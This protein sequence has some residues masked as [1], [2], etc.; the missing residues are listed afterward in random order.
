[1]ATVDGAGSTWNIGGSLIV[2]YLGG[3]GTLTIQNGGVVSNSL[4]AVGFA[5]GSTG[6]VT[7]SGAG[8]TWTSIGQLHVGGIGGSASLTIQSGGSLN[9]GLGLVG[10]DANGPGSV[11]VTGAGSTWTSS[12]DLFVGASSEGTLN[13]ASGGEVSLTG[14]LTVGAFGTVKGNGTITGDVANEGSVAP[15]S[16]VG[17]LHINGDYAQAADGE[18]AIEIASAS[19]YD[20]LEVTGTAMLDGTLRVL[21]LD[22]FVPSAGQSFGFLFASGGFGEPFDALDLPSL[23]AGLSWQ[24]NPGG[25]TVF[26]NVVSAYSADF[27]DDGDVD[28]DDLDQWAGDF[29]VNGMSDADNDGD[30]DGADFLA[31][32]Q[33]FGN[34]PPAAPAA[35]IVPEPSGLAMASLAMFVALV[36]SRRSGARVMVMG[37]SRDRL[38][39]VAASRGIP[40]FSCDVAS[41][42]LESSPILLPT[43]ALPFSCCRMPADE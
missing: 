4:G 21:L 30:S 24:I 42:R 32:Q 7:V 34:G 27:D 28:G 11:T 8:S 10:N 15:G 33:Q 17:T 14:L 20:R 6:M 12:G 18:L 1:V 25:A 22:G 37:K 26:L 2:G 16:S 13:V 29:G 39:S 23:P 31:W 9:S 35:H 3:D 43:S 38:R 19:S 41:M 36:G 40:P 5:N